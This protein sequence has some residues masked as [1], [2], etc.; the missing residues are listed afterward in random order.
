MNFANM[1]ANGVR[2]LAVTCFNCYH[3]AVINVDG[4]PDHVPVPDFEGRLKCTRCGTVGADI[5]PNWNEQRR[6]A[7]PD[8]GAVE[9]RMIH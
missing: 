9:V 8:Q 1:R 3:Q 4:Y 7:E 6:A 5:R 2:S